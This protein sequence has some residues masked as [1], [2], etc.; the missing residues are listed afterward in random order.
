M[1][2]CSERGSGG[3]RSLEEE[4]NTMVYI[5]SYI[6]AKLDALSYQACS[7]SKGNEN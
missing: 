2:H 3:G 7:I 5:P 6:V 1:N 4:N